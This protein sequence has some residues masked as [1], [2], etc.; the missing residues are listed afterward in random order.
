[1]PEWISM[2]LKY[3]P[4]PE[5]DR[6]ATEL[7]G[8]GVIGTTQRFAGQRTVPLNEETTPTTAPDITRYV[9]RDEA[10]EL[11]EKAGLSPKQSAI[12]SAVMAGAPM[13]GGTPSDLL[14][15]ALGY[16]P[17]TPGDRKR[18]AD[19]I[20]WNWNQARPRLIDLAE[21]VW[22]RQGLRSSRE[23]NGHRS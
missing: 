1:M 4:D 6:I 2:E 23:G 16:A 15:A 20:R 21:P 19:A 7:T 14:M 18:A 8:I 17:E 10:N 12:V 13:P 5:L 3:G 11:A 9:L 22:K